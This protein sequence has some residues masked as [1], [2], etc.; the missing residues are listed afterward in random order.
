MLDLTSVRAKLARAQEHAQTIKNEVRSWADRS[1]YS[2]IPQANAECTRYSL[3]LRVNE[4]PPLQRWTLMVGDCFNNLRASLDHLV[5]AIAVHEA[6]PKPPSNEGR[7]RF[8]ITNQRA[9]FDSEVAGGRL[10]TISDPV[11]AAIEDVQPYKRTHPDFPPLLSI[12][13]D[14]NNRDKHK[15][16]RLA[17]GAVATGDIGFVGDYPRDGR[18]WTQVAHSGEIKDSTEIFAFVCDRPTPNMKYDRT[19]FDIVVAIHHGKRDP[20]GPEGS[21]RSDVIT[22]LM[23]MQT[24][25]RKIIYSVVAAVK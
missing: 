8:P 1:P 19:I 21:D 14:L 22:L 13:R 15:L 2:V 17:Y 11:R 23:E 25:V 24:D 7:L 16:L 6:A 20:S 18:I 5:Y 10:G 4:P 12:L 3:V 9:Y